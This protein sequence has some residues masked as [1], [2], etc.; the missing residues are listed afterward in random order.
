VTAPI[1]SPAAL[2]TSTAALAGANPHECVIVDCRFDLAYPDAGQRAYLQ[3]HVPGASYAHLER[4]LSGEIVA[5]RTGR[6]PLPN[7]DELVEHLRGWGI[8][9]DTHVVAYDDRTGAFAARLWWLLRWLGHERVSVCDGGYQAWLAGGGKPSREVPRPRRGNFSPSIRPELVLST[10]D[11]L[12]RDPDVVL[13]DARGAERFRGEVEPI[14]SVAGHIP[15]A[16]SC[17]FAQNLDASGRFRSKDELEARLTQIIGAT[18]PERVVVYCGSGV[19]ACH[20]ILAAAHAGL[21]EFRLYAGSWSEWITCPARPV[22]S[23]DEH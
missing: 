22:A 18:P 6:H 11:V 13:L 4:A 14:D 5:G 9:D 8:D 7:V 15:G 12:A 1:I 17:P 21:G 19:T 10:A 16:R 20:D 2:P 3:G 23:G